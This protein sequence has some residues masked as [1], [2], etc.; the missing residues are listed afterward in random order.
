MPLRLTYKVLKRNSQWRMVEA[1]LKTMSGHYARAG[2]IDNKPRVGTTLTD[3]QLASTKEFGTATEPARP[4]VGPP[5]RRNRKK[6]NDRLSRAVRE[7]RKSK[8][9]EPVLTALNQIGQA[10]VRD[11]RAYVLETPLPG[12]PPPNAPSTLAQKKGTRT[13]VDTH[14]MVDSVKYKVYRKRKR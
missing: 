10:M 13:L 14:Q 5:I 9:V 2:V 7:A 12:I 6:Y 8:R 11:I 4:W 3:A 1:Q